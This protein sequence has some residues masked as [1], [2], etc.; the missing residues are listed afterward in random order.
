MVY[1]QRGGPERVGFL[2]E[3]TLLDLADAKNKKQIE[4]HFCESCFRHNLASIL[5]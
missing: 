2:D 5:L 3:L 4:E 1:L